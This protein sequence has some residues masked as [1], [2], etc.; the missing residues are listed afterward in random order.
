MSDVNWTS[1]EW[2]ARECAG[3][4]TE[5]FKAWWVSYYGVPGDYGDVGDS[6]AEYFVRCA[7]AWRGWKARSMSEGTR[8]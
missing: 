6:T 2:F 4:I 7:F 1:D 5:E 3:E 8:Q